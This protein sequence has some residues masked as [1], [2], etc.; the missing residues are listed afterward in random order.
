[1]KRLQ[2]IALAFVLVVGTA[3]ACG[4]GITA[5]AGIATAQALLDILATVLG[6]AVDSTR[7]LCEVRTREADPQHAAARFDCAQVNDAW[8]NAMTAESDL[9]DALESG[10]Q[11]RIDK[12][13]A[14]LE[15]AVNELKGVLKKISAVA[16]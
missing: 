8:T 9:K 15:K 3:N 2:G 1:M 12:S 11:K 13:T 5:T 10:D 7:A 14:K 6:P 16:P 4:S